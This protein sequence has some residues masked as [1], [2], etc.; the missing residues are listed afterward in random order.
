M[1]SSQAP[2]RCQDMPPYASTVGKHQFAGL[3]V[4]STPSFSLAMISNFVGLYLFWEWRD[5][6]AVFTIAIYCFSPIWSH[7]PFFMAA[8]SIFQKRISKTLLVF[9]F[10]GAIIN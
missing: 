8:T 2:E 5:A 7:H 4:R 3:G 1:P 9:R 10:L 6:S